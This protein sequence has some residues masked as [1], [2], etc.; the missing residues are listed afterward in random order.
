MRVHQNL[1]LISS[2]SLTLAATGCIVNVLGDSTGGTDGTTGDAPTTGN[3][4]EAPTTGNSGDAPTTGSGGDGSCDFATKVQPIFTASCASCHGGAA[5]QLGLDL[6]EGA[7]YAALVG[8]DSTSQPGTLRVAPGDPSASLLL[9]KVGPTPPVGARMPL[10]G[11]L[12]DAEI[13]T[14]EAWVAAGAPESATFACAGDGGGGGE[15]GEVAVDPGGL[16]T[17]EVGGLA[18]LSATVTDPDGAP[19]PDA[20]LAWASSDG[21]TLYVDG[22]GGLLGV[23]PGKATITASAGGVTSAP[24][25]VEVTAASPPAATFAAAR[26]LLVARCAVAGCHVDGVEPGDLRFDRPADQLW[27]KLVG[28]SAFQAPQLLRV[29]PNAPRDSYLL[30]KLALAAP[31]AG[32]RMPFGQPP[33]TAAEVQTLLRWILAGAPFDG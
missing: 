16:V 18:T 9:L 28:E 27:E 25:E 12:S 20:A 13:A 21:L 17:L 14:L 6:G 15:V 32:A 7:A 24:I 3:S 19:L 23:S 33:L 31:F 30:H 26:T 29:A 5:P 2:F 1:S 11:A 4:G 10:G 22:V 8:V